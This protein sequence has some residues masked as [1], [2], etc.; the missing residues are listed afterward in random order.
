MF[1]ARQFFTKSKGLMWGHLKMV[2]IN[3][4]LRKQ[5][6]DLHGAKDGKQN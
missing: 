1:N 5:F 2:K 3:K 4:L 6:V